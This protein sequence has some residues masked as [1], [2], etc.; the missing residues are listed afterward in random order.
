[1]TE[2]FY[3]ATKDLVF[4]KLFGQQAN[5]EITRDLLTSILGREVGKLDLDKNTNLKPL[6]P[7][8]KRGVVDI[9]A[10]EKES[11]ILYNIEMQV[12]AHKNL[13]ERM[14]FY[15]SRMFSSQ[16]KE[17][18]NYKDLNPTILI[19]LLKEDLGLTKE[20]EY[21]HTTWQIME[22]KGKKKILTPNFEMH[23]VELEKYLKNVSEDKQD[24]LRE[25]IEFL[26]NSKGGREEMWDNEKI[27]KARE[28]LA[29]INADP[30]LKRMIELEEKWEYDA[31]TELAVAR[32]EGE[33]IGETRGRK[34]R[35]C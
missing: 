3:P 22:N 4:S 23:I 9:K 2:N 21:P 24:K 19:I 18:K 35:T 31:A 6:Y 27:K 25:W 15:W 30:E 5:E 34:A 20:I 10:E 14:L 26:I 7:G 8:E 1:M 28:E 33:K 29:K 16:L 32:D 17:G 13:E 12:C 11:G